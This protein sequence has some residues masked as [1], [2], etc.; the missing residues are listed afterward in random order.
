MHGAGEQLLWAEQILLGRKRHEAR[1]VLFVERGCPGEGLERPHMEVAV[2]DGIVRLIRVG[3]CVVDRKRRVGLL[4]ISH[5]ALGPAE[6]RAERLLR[7][8]LLG[9]GRAGGERGYG[10]RGEMEAKGHRRLPEWLTA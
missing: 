9:R 10:K 6:G 2:R 4:E 1:H 7:R 5:Q 3:L 8:L